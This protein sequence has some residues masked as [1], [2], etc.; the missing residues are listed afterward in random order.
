MNKLKMTELVVLAQRG[1][2]KAITE[3]FTKMRPL[4]ITSLKKKYFNKFS[5]AE[6]EDVVQES[7]IK[8]F[9][10]LDTFKP[11]Y[12]FSSWLSKICNNTI[13]DCSRK[14]EKRA[15]KFSLDV[16]NSNE[17]ES[18]YSMIST[19]SDGSL[20][21]EENMEKLEESEFAFNILEDDKIPQKLRDVATLLFI[22]EKSYDEIA[23]ELN[24]PLGTVKSRIKR[25]K[26]KASEIIKINI[27]QSYS[28]INHN[29]FCV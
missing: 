3:L 7:I 21:P 16:D 23:E 9:D 10:K 24:L 6:I 29:L 1:N 8:A 15:I 12:S 11:S 19:L 28:N 20:N 27:A 22:F 2:Q 25:F 26:E 18:S 17:E 4:M 5:D 14:A 13:I